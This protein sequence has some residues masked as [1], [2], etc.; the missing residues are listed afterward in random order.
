MLFRST[1]GGVRNSVPD[2]ESAEALGLDPGP[3]VVP[4]PLVQRLVAGPELR[5]ENAL[6]AVDA[7]GGVAGPIR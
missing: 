6:L 5:R 7:R 1:D 2:T 3:V 4:S